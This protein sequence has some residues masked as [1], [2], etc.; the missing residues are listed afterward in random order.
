MVV[1]VWTMPESKKA[2]NSPRQR[3]GSPMMMRL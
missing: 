3:E 1:T 2:M